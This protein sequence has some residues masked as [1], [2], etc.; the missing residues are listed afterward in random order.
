M[1]GLVA[2]G[3]GSSEHPQDTASHAR[4]VA[5]AGG[6]PEAN[7]RCD[8]SQP[9]RESSEYDTSGDDRPDVRKVFQRMGEAPT[10]RL[11][12]ICREADLNGDGTKDVVRFYNDEGRPL[13]EEAD[14][15]FDGQMDEISYF[16]QGRVQRM[17]NDTNHDGRIDA[18]TFYE[19]GQPVR[20]ERDT[21]GRSTD[22]EWH[23]DRW[24]YFDNGRMV[25][26]G[27]DLDGD[28]V[29]DRWDRDDSQRRQAEEEAPAAAENQTDGG[30]PADAAAAA[31]GGAHA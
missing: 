31:D 21:A 13:R 6:T 16:E 30:V 10:T 18:K 17:E 9:N 20:T 3:G 15:D 1:L 2:C 5:T 25:R 23:P 14:R 19:R 11:V 29:V 8:A 22:T 12:L 26:V 27:A 7:N 4:A 28:S 24:E